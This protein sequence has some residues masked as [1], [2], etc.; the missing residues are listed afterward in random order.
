MSEKINI[1]KRKSK[2]NFC[3]KEEEKKTQ[4]KQDSNK[5]C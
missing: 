3:I 2:K 5:Y 4:K 1:L